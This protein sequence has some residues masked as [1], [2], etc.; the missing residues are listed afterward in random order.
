VGPIPEPQREALFTT[1]AERTL[2]RTIG[3]AD[4]IAATHLFLVEN[5]F[6]TGTVLTVDGD[7]VL[8]GS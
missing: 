8:T 2:T 7:F 3:E 4:Q 1:L 6:V 5:H